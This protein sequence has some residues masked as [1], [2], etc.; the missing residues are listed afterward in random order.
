MGTTEG[1]RLMFLK[2]IKQLF[3]LHDTTR[4]LIHSI[5]ERL[6]VQRTDIYR[7]EQKVE[8]LE[9]KWAL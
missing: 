3:K 4:L 6:D 2:D 1:E 9:K 8:E 7:L 5:H